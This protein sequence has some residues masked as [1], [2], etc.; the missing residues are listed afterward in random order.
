MKKSICKKTVILVLVAV[1][2]S[3]VFG[4]TAC[5]KKAPAQK[6][7]VFDENVEKIHA[8]GFGNAFKEIIY[9][10]SKG[11]FE[12]KGLDF[13]RNNPPDTVKGYL[14]V[15]TKADELLKNSGIT[16]EQ[17]VKLTNNV[18]GNCKQYA[19]V[20]L[21]Y[22]L[23]TP[24]DEK[25]VDE[26]TT[27]ENAMSFV[28]TF[29]SVLGKDNFAKFV[30][31]LFEYRLV[32]WVDYHTEKHPNNDLD[33]D[34]VNAKKELATFRSIQMEEFE[35]LLCGTLLI[36]DMFSVKV[37]TEEFSLS[38]SETAKLLQIPDFNVNLD[39]AQWTFILNKLGKLLPGYYGQLY[40][41]AYPARDGGIGTIAGKME[42]VLRLLS[43][44]QEMMDADAVNMSKNDQMN[45]LAV[46]LVHQMT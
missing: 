8:T 38:D 37:D 42:I 46:K 27:K 4:L 23:N 3:S 19:E 15:A 12:A 30:Y 36:V 10:S 18:S 16:E 22:L 20:L 26:K 43:R 9:S 7:I 40:I 34:V 41:V 14:A 5:N 21:S 24:V 33:P 1:L 6:G 35:K 11:F 32:W 25:Y 2:L 45:E 17:Y 31:D 29:C 44:F 13:D 28:L 39:Y